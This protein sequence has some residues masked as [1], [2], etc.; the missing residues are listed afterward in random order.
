MSVAAQE[1]LSPE[2]GGFEAGWGA[3]VS[4]SLP[5]GS[6]ICGKMNAARH[7][8]PGSLQSLSLL[9]REAASEFSFLC[10]LFPCSPGDCGPAS[11]LLSFLVVPEH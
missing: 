8:F 1:D 4:Y 11:C 9:W 6:F 3:D 7:E 10:G 5:S 2:D